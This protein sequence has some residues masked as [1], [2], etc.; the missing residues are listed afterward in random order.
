MKRTTT[1]KDWT[2][3][4]IL[5][6]QYSDVFTVP[7]PENM[8]EN[9]EEFFS[10]EHNDINDDKLNAFNVTLSLVFEAI[11]TLPPS[12][13]PGPDGIPAILIKQLKFELA[14]PLEVLFTKSMDT[15]VI[16]DSFLQAHVKPIKKPKK[17]RSDPASYR[18]LSL[19]SNLMKVFEH[20][21]KKQLQ[22]H[23]EHGDRL[24][25]SQHGFRPNR[26]CITQLLGHY[27]NIIENLEAG[28][29]YDVIYLDFAKAFDTVDRFIL[30]KEMK[31]LGV[32][33]K[34][35]TWLFNFL[36]KRTQ[37]IIAENN[38]SAPSPVTSGV[39]Q[40]TVLGPQMFLMMINSLAEEDL[41]SRITMFADDTRVGKEILDNEDIEKLQQDLDSIFRW[42]KS[43]NMAFNN[44]KFEIVRH[45]NLFRTTSSIPRGKYFTDDDLE[46]ETKH[47]VRDLGIQM[48]EDADFS[49]HISITCKKARDKSNWIYRNFYSRDVKFLSFMWR[50]YIQPILDYGS[51]LWSPNKQ[52]EI[53]QLEDI[54]KNFSSRAQKDNKESFNFWE[55]IVRYGVRS[56][57]RRSERFRIICIWKLLEKLIPNCGITVSSN[58]LR[59]R[60]CN[61]PL[62]PFYASD[63][64]KT[65]RENSFNVRG[66]TLFNNLPMSIRNISNC[67][68]NTFK[69]ALDKYLN[70]F[71]DT[72]LS[73]T[74]YPAPVDWFTSRP[75]NSL[76]DWTRHMS[77]PIRLDLTLSEICEKVKSSQHYIDHFS[78]S[79]YLDTRT[80][81]HSQFTTHDS[82]TE[83]TEHSEDSA[84]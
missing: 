22:V 1:T 69:N 34:A 4:Q 16:P 45:G 58:L 70:L 78:T 82:P 61:I 35:A 52:L 47:S 62:S 43:H 49:E 8:F 38:I 53:K 5:S 31:S 59:G 39:P 79:I 42:Q 57:Q 46:I 2:E 7:A 77:I 71:P 64:V 24:N 75:S 44:D 18:P 11:D 9:V 40:G 56:Q 60:S 27:N 23:L 19:T 81:E 20:L 74:Y 76:V 6:K 21:V 72:P 48:S 17:P 25:S 13:S 33:N 12:P 28:K 63:R 37:R 30:A 55:R 41:E 67:S 15:G 73:Q 66:A 36:D 84:T 50:S 3:A 10:E 65:L 26:S 54:F 80:S 32:Q 14:P 68:I 83:H 29:L 51:Q